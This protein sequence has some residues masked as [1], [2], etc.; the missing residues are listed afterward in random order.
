MIVSFG[1]AVT[2][3]GHAKQ[4]TS[5]AVSSSTCTC[6]VGDTSSSRNDC[7]LPPRPNVLNFCRKGLK[8]PPDE[9]DPAP[10]LIGAGLGLLRLSLSEDRS[11]ACLPE[12]ST[13]AE[14][15][16]FEVGEIGSD[17]SLPTASNRADTTG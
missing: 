3:A 7:T 4:L 12:T 13:P 1:I 8:N 16:L 9:L 10:V 2:G 6:R 15:Q 17:P 5:A 11:F 14:L